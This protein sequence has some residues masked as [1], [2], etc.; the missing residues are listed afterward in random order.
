MLNLFR[1]RAKN[2]YVGPAR[3]QE[4]TGRQE[5][6]GVRKKS[7]T[8]LPSRSV[9]S[10]IFGLGLGL[11]LFL[12]VG[13]GLFQIYNYLTTS[14]Y[15][16]IKNISVSGVSHLSQDDILELC[17]LKPGMNSLTVNISE[18]E[19]KLYG[20]PW[21]AS[22]SV[23]RTL[24]DSFEIYVTEH[25]PT[26]WV[27]INGVMH[28]ANK[29]G[30]PIAPVQAQRFISLPILEILEDGE[31][32]RPNV[33]KLLLAMQDAQ[34]PIDVRL[35]SIIRVSASSGIEIVLGDGTLSLCIQPDDWTANLARLHV[36]LKDLARRG[37]LKSTREIWSADGN[38]WVIPQR[39][40]K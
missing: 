5:S 38:V 40:A 34:L 18:V 15:F 7:G 24:P 27:L 29:D 26:F 1:R 12:G 23:K 8:P 19:Q 36:V 11:L 2:S 17:G 32:L 35:A 39:G 9:V 10:W 13:M 28:Y 37:E 21:I 25:A 14:S 16:N 3:K 20:N 30:R 22:V 33:G 6:K 4:K 31:A